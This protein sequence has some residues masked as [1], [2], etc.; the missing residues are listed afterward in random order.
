MQAGNASIVPRQRAGCAGQMEA[1]RVSE[2]LREGVGS[3]GGGR[4]LPQ[5]TSCSAKDSR[6]L[7]VQAHKNALENLTQKSA[8]EGRRM[9]AIALYGTVHSRTRAK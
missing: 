9:N 1:R 7:F 3:L 6:P 2:E 5:K 8:G 4:T